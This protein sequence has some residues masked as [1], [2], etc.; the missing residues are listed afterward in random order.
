MTAPEPRKVEFYRH[1]LGEEEMASLS[2]T[3][4]S[5]F[6][7]TGPRVAEFE[8]VLG[9]YL[10]VP[11]IV[12]VS[13]CTDGMMITL[14]A[15]GIGA[16]DEVITTPMTFIATPNTVLHVGATPMFVEVDRDTGLMDPNAVEAAVTPRTKAILTVHLY[17]QMCDMRAL[18]A[19]ADRYHLVLIEDSAHGVEMRRDDVGPGTLSD[20]AVFSFYAT[21][22]LTCGDGG[23][24]AVRDPAVAERLRRLRNHGMTKGA[25]S[26]YTGIYRHWDMVEL[27]YKCGLS[28]I[29]ASILLPQISRLERRRASRESAVC[30]YE[31]LLA[32]VPGTRLIR[33]SGKSSHHLFTVLAPPGRR[34][35]LLE[36]LGSAR[37]GVA[38]N[39]RAVHLL[40]YY[41]QRFGFSPGV[42]PNAE[43]IGERTLS[44]PLYPWI[45]DDD[46]DYVADQYRRFVVDGGS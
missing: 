29:D 42:F 26:R 20:A 34:D 31:R 25:A 40:T 16:G 7:T 22:T 11:H 14:L 41:R 19:V 23:A 44:L 10:G 27:G 21:K 3:V 37:I 9:E 36:K 6:L 17:G 15:F 30:R 24:I 35:E 12:G 33:R 5:V 2:T 4:H 32:D 13:S 18:R 39:Y 46:V 38:V 1:D 8:K 43:E 45:S 28:D